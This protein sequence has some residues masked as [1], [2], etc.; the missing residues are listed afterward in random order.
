L[1]DQLRGAKTFTGAAAFDITFTDN[2]GNVIRYWLSGTTLRKTVGGSP[3]GGAIVVSDVQSLTF[4]YWLW[5]GT[6]WSTSTAPSDLGQI[7]A[8][9]ITVDAR[10]NGFQRQ[11]SSFVKCRNL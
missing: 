11:L 3:S 2:S 1:A 9:V 4:T 10:V 8:A 5:N 6:S 7:R